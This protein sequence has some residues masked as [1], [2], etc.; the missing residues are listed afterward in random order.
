MVDPTLMLT[1]YF[2]LP[3]AWYLLISK[4]VALTKK[5]EQKHDATNNDEQLP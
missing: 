4:A 1:L 5:G 3:I 2:L